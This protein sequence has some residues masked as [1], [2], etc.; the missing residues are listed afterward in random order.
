[1]SAC[2]VHRV[3]PMPLP[4]L[5][6]WLSNPCQDNKGNFNTN[7]NK[8]GQSINHQGHANYKGIKLSINKGKA[9]NKGSFNNDDTFN[10][11]SPF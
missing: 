7:G 10:M 5:C 1:M 6:K 9:N 2:T 4:D 3:G 11:P 8:Q